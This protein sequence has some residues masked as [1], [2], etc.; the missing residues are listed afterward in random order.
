[1]HLVTL[2]WQVRVLTELL[3]G[4]QLINTSFANESKFFWDER[5]AS[6]EIQTTMP[7]KDHGEMGFSGTNG[8]AAFSA[9]LSKLSSIGYYKDLFKFVYGSEEITEAKIQSALGQ[10][11][12]SIQAF[13]SK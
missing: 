12:K 2:Q 10:F 13:D 3:A 8:D 6:L 5:A 1:M 4:M 11:I 9:L 7:I